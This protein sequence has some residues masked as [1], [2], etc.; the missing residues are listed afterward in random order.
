MGYFRFRRRIKIA[1]GVSLNLSK[2]GISTSL[3]GKGFTV[4]LGR[5]KTRT[6]ASL[7]GTGLSYATTQKAA[8]TSRRTPW[9]LLALLVL[10]FVVL[11]WMMH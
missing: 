8:D 1:P 11:A 5:G 10:V 7:P 6:T 3:G 4:N 2:S 9:V